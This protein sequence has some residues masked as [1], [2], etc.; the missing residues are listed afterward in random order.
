MIFF[1]D[2]AKIK[3][4]IKTDEDAEKLQE[5]LEKL[6][7]WDAKN[8]MIFDGTKFQA[9]RYGQNGDLKNS[10]MYFT[11]NME[12]VIQQLSYIWDLGVMI[13]DDARFDTHIAKVVSNLGKR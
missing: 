11:A 9:V 7:S 2:Y 4:S 10:T 12:D 13:S 8:R 5:N 1:V 6:Y 3:D